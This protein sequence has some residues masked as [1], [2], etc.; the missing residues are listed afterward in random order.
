MYT[1][2]TDGNRVVAVEGYVWDNE[3][4]DL[5]EWEGR[6]GGKTVYFELGVMIPPD[7]NKSY[8]CEVKRNGKF[9]SA[10]HI[11]DLD[12]RLRRLQ[13]WSDAHRDATHFS[14]LTIKDVEPVPGDENFNTR[15][16]YTCEGVKDVKEGGKEWV[17]VMGGNEGVRRIPDTTRYAGRICD[18]ITDHMTFDEAMSGGDLLNL[19]LGGLTDVDSYMIHIGENGKT[20]GFYFLST[21]RDQELEEAG[22]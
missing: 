19:N 5:V 16:I 21:A 17:V 1:Y 9:L 11:D 7:D 6:L 22:K 15:Y 13:I 4:K 2:F 20:K 8:L 12:A 14:C 10:W 3:K 18:Y